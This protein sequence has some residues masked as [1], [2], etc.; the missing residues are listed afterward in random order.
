MNVILKPGYN[1]IYSLYKA[2]TNTVEIK[3]AMESYLCPLQMFMELTEG[4]F[5]YGAV[6]ILKHDLNIKRIFLTRV[7]LKYFKN[8]ALAI[9]DKNNPSNSN[10]T[11]QP[12]EHLP[13]WNNAVSIPLFILGVIY[14]IARTITRRLLKSGDKTSG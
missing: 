12:T 8:I 6:K 13:L 4:G 3:M 10:M 5:N 2:F 7:T 11:S 9:S 1:K 14:A